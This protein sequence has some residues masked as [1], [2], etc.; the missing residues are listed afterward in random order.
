MDWKDVPCKEW[1]GTR[2]GGYGQA[3][4]RGKRWLVHRLAWTEANGPIPGGLQ[5]M[6][7]CNNPA[8]H[9]PAHLQVGTAKDN[10]GYMV[11]CG[12]SQKG[13][14]CPSK[15][16]GKGSSKLT[17]EQKTYALARLL[18]GKETQ[19]QVADAFGVS[20]STIWKAWRVAQE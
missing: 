2:V 12:R 8:C 19:Q 3:T 20:K 16:R 1:T 13:K 9:E 18:T 10:S 11:K 4:I 14:P 5:V 6:H 15:D 7:L 17:E